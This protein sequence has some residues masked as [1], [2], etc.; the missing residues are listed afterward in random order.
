MREKLSSHLTLRERLPEGGGEGVPS[1]S[2]TSSS[3]LMEREMGTGVMGEVI[4]VVVVVVV[5]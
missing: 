2:D 3:L 1:E 4:T 5:I